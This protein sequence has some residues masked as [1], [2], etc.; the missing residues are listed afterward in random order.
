MLTGAGRAY[1]AAMP[2]DLPSSD[3]AAE[4]VGR[5]WLADAVRTWDATGS[6]Y[7]F[8]TGAPGTGKS[9]AV[10][11]L[12][13]GD[14]V[15]GTAV[16]R[17]R[18]A[19]RGSCDPVRFAESLAEQFGT[20]VPG[21]AEALVRVS[22]DWPGAGDVRIEGTA[23]AGTV[24]PH[25][26]V[27][28]AKV[29]LSLSHVT[30]DEAFEHLVCR[31]LE[32]LAP[33]RRPVVVVDALDEALTHR[34]RR[35]IAE[36][37]LAGTDR[38]PLRF[39]LT[40]RH[41]AR[42]TAAVRN[43]PDAV[44]VD[45]V[46]DAPDPAADLLAY[47]RH[48]L[49]GAPGAEP[50]REDLAHR[51]AAA[52][53]GNYL[54]VRYLT[55]EVADG[56]RTVDELA[57]SV[58]P[59]GLDGVYR[60]FVQREIRP[61]GSADAEERWRTAFR[62]VLDLLV[63][64]REDGFTADRMADLLGWTEQEVLDTVRVLGQ[65]LRGRG[66]RGP[67]TLFHRSFE[68]FL[69]SGDDPHLDAGE[70]HRRIADRAFATWTDAWDACDDPYLAQHLTDHLLTAAEST[71]G[72]PARSRTHRDRLYALAT[73]PGYLAAQ[74]TVAP[75]RDLHLVT[76]GRALETSLAAHAHA[77][78]VRVALDLVRAR[79]EAD[80]ETPVQAALL[81]GAAAGVAKARTHPQDTALLWLLLIVAA[82]D[83]RS[84]GEAVA[85]LREIAP[86]GFETAGYRW[87]PAIAALLA[88]L[89]PRLAPQDAAALL[90]VADDDLLGHLA[91]FVLEEA[92]PEP[93]ALPALRIREAV[94]RARA[95]EGILTRAALAALTEPAGP[96]PGGLARL[97][98][99]IAPGHVPPPADDSGWTSPLREPDVADSVLL[100]Y[101]AQG[102]L[103]ERLLE[104]AD[105]T[106]RV[107]GVLSDAAVL[108]GRI[109]QA[110]RFGPAGAARA[111]A[112]G[113][114]ALADPR[115]DIR[116]LLHHTAAMVRIGDRTAP[117]LLDALVKELPGCHDDPHAGHVDAFHG[118]CDV[119]L[120]LAVVRLLAAAGQGDRAREEAGRLR[121]DHPA[122]HVRA[123][124]WLARDETRPG[125]RAALVAA[126]REAA[127]R[128]PHSLCAQ[129]AL[130]LA[131]ADRRRLADT[132]A[133]TA[134]RRR[135]TPAVVGPARA[136]LAW[137][138]H[139]RGDH[140]RAE[141]LGAEAAAWFTALPQDRRL[142]QDADRLVK[143]LLRA[144]LP[145]AAATVARTPTA[146]GESA[147]LMNLGDVRN[148]LAAHAEYA[149]LALLREAEG[150]APGDPARRPSPYEQALEARVRR[151]G[152]DRRAFEESRAALRL[153][154]R[155]MLGELAQ[156][157]EDTW[158]YADGG[159]GGAVWCLL[160]AIRLEWPEGVAAARWEWDRA[161]ERATFAAASHR[162]PGAGGRRDVET[163]EELDVLLRRDVQAAA[164]LA[165]ASHDVGD[166]GEAASM[167][168]RA[169]D[170]ARELAGP[171]HRLR[172]F[173]E[174]AGTAARLGRYD[175]LR[176][177]WPEAA[178]TR[179]GSLAEVAETLAVTVL[180]GGPDAAAARDALEEIVGSPGLPDLD[181]VDLLA[182]LAVITPD[183]EIEELLLG[184][185]AGPGR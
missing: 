27:I 126:A 90:D 11:H 39:V 4:F 117:A 137:A 150:R 55:R 171:G 83:A 100:V 74:R 23:T 147:G 30:A 57:V 69:I 125:P 20:T 133:R 163:R 72:S 105:R 132:L 106:A 34:G 127:D 38:L 29:S 179:G 76:L 67:W 49:R 3:A 101:A 112:A 33:A 154:V 60:E 175:D 151:A 56:I 64:A 184:D 37:V 109:V 51:L 156:V 25:A 158:F 89:M 8:L 73:S 173:T 119:G 108:L 10:E 157:P 114:A 166:D 5:G 61:A 99:L 68:E 53:E 113:L 12:W 35:T 86:A 2:A 165:E 95:V 170:S 42:V 84:S 104:L 164:E 13:G 80:E 32:L 155:G 22:R 124:A 70:G 120:R 115:R 9:A 71:P 139:V 31:P 185:P 48:R 17:C 131:D 103:D 81:R 142:P 177:L 50:R 7:L 181:H 152:D 14:P 36:L 123:L 94:A 162:P 121:A 62:P 28:G 143:N 24:H 79:T 174:L 77:R 63:A 26:S 66:R 59:H 182:V 19:S 180:R 178:R 146:H 149:E 43:L 153:T 82:L 110:A 122:E 148:R 1:P 46:E 15:A 111:R 96:D 91:A 18:A 93:A 159:E 78:S 135:H 134:G 87:S 118:W 128:I 40:S 41:D 44:V 160:Q 176:L 172:A 145:A 161:V 21:F 85:A 140:G 136:A 88:P 97:G 107:R 130:V 141:A 167:F 52:G 65:Y 138:A 16:H 75:G 92:G 144:R 183:A 168:S 129:A 58:L 169:V 47:A 102:E 116:G 54:Y 45:L 6:T 98:A